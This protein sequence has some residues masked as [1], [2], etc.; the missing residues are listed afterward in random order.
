MPCRLH[1]RRANVDAW[2]GYAPRARTVRCGRPLPKRRYH[3]C[4]TATSGSHPDG[5]LVEPAIPTVLNVDS[6]QAASHQPPAGL[7]SPG[8]PGRFS[9]SLSKLHIIPSD[10]L[11]RGVQTR[12]GTEWQGIGSPLVLGLASFLLGTMPLQVPALRPTADGAASWHRSGSGSPH[13]RR[14]TPTG[15][16]GRSSG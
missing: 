12:T 2:R 15:E 3:R 7:H 10:A 6:P 1:V 11:A 5:D 8:P 4:R 9:R 16:A 13:P 14:S